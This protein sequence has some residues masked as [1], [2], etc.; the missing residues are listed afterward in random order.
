[1]DPLRHS[2]INSNHDVSKPTLAST[3]PLTKDQMDAMNNILDDQLNFFGYC[4]ETQAHT[5]EAARSY[6]FNNYLSASS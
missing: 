4:H 6:K 5:Q 2:F 1:M 3:T